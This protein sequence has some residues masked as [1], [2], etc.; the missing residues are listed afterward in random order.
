MEAI[1]E[2]NL[3]FKQFKKGKV[4]DVY[5]VNDEKLLLVMSDRIS[6]YDHVLHELIPNKGVCL[7][8]LSAFWFN[9]FKED[10]ESHMISADVEE[11]PEDIKRYK[12]RIKGRSML[13]KKADV[14]PVECIV[15]GYISGSAWRSY[16]DNGKVCGIELQEGMK[17]SEKF[18]EPLFTPSTKAET[19]HDVNISFEKMKE[20]IGDE[21]AEKLKN[22]SLT[23]YKK[24]SEYARKKGI[25]IADTKFEFGKIDD[26]IIVVDEVLTPDSSRFW[27]AD[28][29]QPGKK[30]PSF[31]KQYVRDYLTDT[32]WDK[33][34]SPPNLPEEV[35]EGTKKRYL[36]AYEKITGEK[37][38]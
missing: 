12:D 38:F 2:I 27:P 15:R 30:Q 10:I 29:Y 14:F 1:T 23:M 4:R 20:L 37:L 32:G 11:F 6:A 5:E 3:P 9:F 25:I 31:D 21:N 34:S 17:E 13:V 16:Q 26:E 24:G 19:G 35:I 7:T 22:L 18:E 33:N 36:E 28:E 8:Q